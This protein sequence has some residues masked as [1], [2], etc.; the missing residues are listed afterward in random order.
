MWNAIWF[1]RCN[2]ERGSAAHISEAYRLAAIVLRSASFAQAPA[3]LGNDRVPEWQ[4]SCW[5]LF[6][7]QVLQ[8]APRPL[9]TCALALVAVH[10]V[11]LLSPV[12]LAIAILA[13]PLLVPTFLFVG[14]SLAASLARQHASH[15][16]AAA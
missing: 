8:A 14:V 7:L 4:H 12:L 6:M 5:V 13:S 2:C 11:L 10:L 3:I 1:E 16:R 15:G 9:L